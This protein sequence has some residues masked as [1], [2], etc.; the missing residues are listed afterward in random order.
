MADNRRAP[1]E[2]DRKRA[3]LRDVRRKLRQVQEQLTVL[4]KIVKEIARG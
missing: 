3:E 2:Y 1:T 4:R